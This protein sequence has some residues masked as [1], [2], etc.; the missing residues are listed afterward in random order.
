M[1]SV[2]CVASDPDGA[3]EPDD[4]SVP[5]GAVSGGAL[6]SACWPRTTAVVAASSP[7]ATAA[8]FLRDVV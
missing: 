3:A 1:S 7:A 5:A 8:R 6:A 2:A 4:A